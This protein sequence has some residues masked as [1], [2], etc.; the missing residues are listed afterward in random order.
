MD[1]I[2]ADEAVG[3]NDQ[4]S[5]A[6]YNRE[7]KEENQE[8][9]ALKALVEYLNFREEEIQ[10]FNRHVRL[11]RIILLYETRMGRITVIKAPDYLNDKAAQNLSLKFLG[12]YIDDDHTI[13]DH[14]AA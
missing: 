9:I 10:V 1:P 11:Q 3:W 2:E 14:T 7:D 12:V 5:C 6:K 8:L 4:A 13:T